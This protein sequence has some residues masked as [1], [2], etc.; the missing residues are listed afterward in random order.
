M[1]IVS[2]LL[3]FTFVGVCLGAEVEPASTVQAKE[4]SYGGRTG[5]EWM[6]LAKDKDKDPQI[7]VHAM[8]RLEATGSAA[9]IPAFVEMLHDKEMTVANAA[10]LALGRI[11]PAA[12]PALTEA[13]KDEDAGARFCRLGPGADGSQGEDGS[14]GSHRSAERPGCTRPFFFCAGPWGDW[15]RGEDGDPRPH[16]IAQR[17]RQGRSLGFGQGLRGDRS[18]G[19]DGTPR[20]H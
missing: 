16:R 17:Q 3:A 19:E 1:R 2:V 18:R 9:A 11:G 10:A 7:R 14:P 8:G 12:V 4:P 6:A 20:P 13:L 15:S 5:S